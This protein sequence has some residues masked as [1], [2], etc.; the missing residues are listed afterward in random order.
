MANDMKYLSAEEEAKLLKPIDEYIGKIQKQ[1]DALRKDGSDKVQELKT[2]ISLVRE[3]K[4][5]TKEEQAEI[6][7]KDKEQM[8]KAK[9]TEAANKD[10]V[11]KLIAEAED[12]LKAH[13]KKDYYDKVAASCAAQ[14]EQENAE[15]RK[16]REELKKEHESSLAKL[17]DKQ[18]IKDEKYV[19]K[20]R[21]YDAQMLH[22][23]K[24]QEILKL[25]IE[26]TNYMEN[27][28]AEVDGSVVKSNDSAS[29]LSAMT[30]ELSATM[31]DVGLAVN[32]IND[33]ADNIL[34][35]VEIIAT[36]SDDINQFSKEM[37]A[38][39]EKIESDA[40]YNMV[41][42]GEKVGNILD[43]LNKAIEDSKSVDQVNNLTNDILNISSQTNLLALNASIEAARAGEAGKGFA[44]VADEIRQLAD[45]SRETANKIQSI[46]SVV[47]AAVNNLS[48]NANNLVSYLQQTILPEF[49]TFVDG[50]VR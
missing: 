47:V 16:V 49:Q 12:Y 27:V 26:N 14:K 4:N 36:K 13:F 3:N 40:R 50:G 34:K 38:N 2:H 5:Y 7:R 28:V 21:L 11:S 10:K 33:N 9:E 43:V 19:Y 18:E 1:I 46:N 45:S 24:L 44:V 37:K 31:Q 48:D 41:Q 32:T 39:A 17:S 8:V 42:T 35:D 15:Y 23:S 20:N 30:E 22:E 29:D 6:I 25:I